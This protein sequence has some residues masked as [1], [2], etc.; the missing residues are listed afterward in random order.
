MGNPSHPAEMV[1]FLTHTLGSRVSFAITKCVAQ[2]GM[3]IRIFSLGF[4]L[5]H[6]GVDP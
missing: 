5:E 1:T 2:Q 4:A 3:R 6:K